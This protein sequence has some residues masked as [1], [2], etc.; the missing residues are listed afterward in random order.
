[1]YPVSFYLFVAD[2]ADPVYVCNFTSFG[3]LRLVDEKDDTSVGDAL[4][5]RARFS[6]SV[7]KKS[8]PFVGIGA[9]PNF[10]CWA[11]KKS[12]EGVFFLPSASWGDVVRAS[13][14]W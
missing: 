6:Y 8:I 2:V 4:A 12:V 5:F 13:M 9:G 10:I 1:M 14:W 7:G 3:D 11:F